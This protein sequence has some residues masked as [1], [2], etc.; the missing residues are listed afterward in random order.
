M[1]DLAGWVNS[2]IIVRPGTFNQ[3]GGGRTFIVSGIGRGGTTM[4]AATLRDAGIPMGDALDEASVEDL[5]VSVALRQS[6]RTMLERL[7]VNRNIQ[8]ADW[9]FKS[10]S[11]HALLQYRELARFRNPHLILIF[12]DPVAIAQRAAL[13]DYNDP[14]PVL[15]D[16]SSAIHNL[17]QVFSNTTC[18]AL[19]LSYEKALIFPDTFVESLISFCGLPQDTATRLRRQVTPNS[20]VYADGTAVKM[21]GYLEALR[22]DILSGWCAYVKFMDPIS[23]DLFLNDTKILT[24]L[25][26]THRADVA[27]AGYG[28]GDSGFEIDISGFALTP[29]DRLHVRPT[30]RPL[31]ELHNSGRTVAEYRQSGP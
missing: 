21:V 8:H 25:A 28:N 17:L 22:G 9:G 27:Q 18:P 11:I 7:I 19:L 5:D 16:V 13:S 24:F 1:A 15:L 23:L 29:D 6:D 20:K 10:P 14:L 4:V 3:P 30:R 12:R 26:Q 2:G 31:F